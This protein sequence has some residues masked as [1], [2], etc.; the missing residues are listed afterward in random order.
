MESTILQRLLEADGIKLPSG[1]GAE[2]AVR[3]FGP[4]HDD[5]TA[6]MSVNVARDVYNCHGCG[7]K[8]NA[9]TYL[10]EVRGHDRARAVEILEQHGAPPTFAL[11]SERQVQERDRSLKALPGQSHETSSN[12]SSW[13]AG[14][15]NSSRSISTRT[16]TASCS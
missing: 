2:K 11:A 7:L 10:T 5:T 1:G 14:A 6:S 13:A 9:W 8:G 16:R 3:C 4:N 15:R 12:P